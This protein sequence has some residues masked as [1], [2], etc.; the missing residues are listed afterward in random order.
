MTPDEMLEC[1]DEAARAVLDAVRG[2]GAESLRTRTGV[3]GQ[4]ALD[5]VADAAALRVLSKAPAHIVSEE[6]GSHTRTGASVTFVLDPIDGST[7]CS[8]GIAYW[9][10]SICALDADGPVAALVA[11]HASGEQT[12]ATRGGGA[13]RNG[14]AL[15]ASGVERIE[16]AVVALSG[17]PR[18]RLPWKQFRALGCMSLTL[19]DVAAGGIDGYLDTARHHAP[20]DY[21]GG[22]LACVEAG[23]VVREANGD[24]FV[25]D[26]PTARHQLVAAATAALADELQRR[27]AGRHDEETP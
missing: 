10:T 23:A 4:Y 9:G 12:L 14:A 19:C 2:I 8:R 7:N 1:F 13:R 20:W 3:A 15:R 6:S 26:D 22:Y 21:L 11:N 24:D 18:E 5:L 27:A 17:F 16:D 25:T